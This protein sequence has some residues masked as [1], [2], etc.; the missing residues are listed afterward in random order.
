MVGGWRRLAVGAANTKKP[1]DVLVSST[2][3][4]TDDVFWSS[5]D[6]ICESLLFV[7]LWRFV[8]LGGCQ[9]YGNVGREGGCRGLGLGVPVS[10]LRIA[11]ASFVCGPIMVVRCIFKIP[12]CDYDMKGNI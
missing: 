10:N 12:L 9:P 6:S 2:R 8:L 1:I 7:H 11:N 4:Y 3:T 5:S